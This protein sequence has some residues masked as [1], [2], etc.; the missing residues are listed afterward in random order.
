MDPSNAAMVP[1]WLD[2]EHL[3]CE[4]LQAK[5]GIVATSCPVRDISNRQRQGATPRDGATLL[6]SLTD[7]SNTPKRTLVIKQIPP[8]GQALSQRLGLAR[9][10]LFYKHLAS[11]LATDKKSGIPTIYYAE[12]DMES[13]QKCI[14]ME[15]LAKEGWVDSGIFFGPGNP[16]NWNRNLPDMLAACTGPSSPPPPSSEEVA[17]ATFRAIAHT[18]AAYWKNESL[19]SSQYSWLRGHDWLQ[20][21][22][23]DTWEASQ[24]M[25]RSIWEKCYESRS[26]KSSTEESNSGMS[27]IEWNPIVREAVNKAVQGISWEAQCQRLQ[28][29][30]HWTLVHGDFW[31]GNV[32]WKIKCRD[33]DDNN[34]RLLDWEMVGLGSGPQDLGQYVLSNFDPTER[35]AC[36]RRLIQSYYKELQEAGFTDVSWNYCWREYSVGGLER[37]L[38]FLV[39]FLGQEMFDW[40]QFFHNQIAEFMQDH[41]LSAKDIT[42]PRP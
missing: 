15:H 42:Q 39:W 30:G 29:K 21:K 25:I 9:E 5:T 6:L 27:D 19:L 7:W 17:L 16:N 26:K 3:S 41:A 34:L 33:A 2:D 35:R 37:W 36:E 11:Q 8:S 40:A 23:R 31:P 38:W 13:G 10:G 22:G 12:G 28:V 32:M 1:V 4:W 14:I 24:H 20:G 18:H